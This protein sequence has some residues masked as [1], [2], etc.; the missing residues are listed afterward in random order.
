MYLRMRKLIMSYHPSLTSLHLYLKKRKKQLFIFLD[1]FHN[2][3]ESDEVCTALNYFLE[4]LPSNVN[5]VF[6]SRRD[7]KKI[8]YPKFL[9]KNWMG[10]I[11]TSDLIFNNSDIDNFIKLNKRKTDH[12]DKKLL[13]EF[14]KTTEG[15]VTA[16]QLLM[17]TKNFQIIKKEDIEQSQNDIFEYFTNE[18]YDSCS[19]GEKN[20]LLTLSYP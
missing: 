3:D 5:L 12:L 4:Y 2:I 17:M 13:E 16:I 1:D 18:I 7:P 8:N 10:R 20:L 19:E 11:T 15:W 6:I 14:L 9:A